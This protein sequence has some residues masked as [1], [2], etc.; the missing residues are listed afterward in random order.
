[1]M[2]DDD[3]DDGHDDIEDGDSN[4]NYNGIVHSNDGDQ[5]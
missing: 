3:S 5:S 1:M 4:D 2:H